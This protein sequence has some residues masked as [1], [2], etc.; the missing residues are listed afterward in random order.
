MFKKLKS[1]PKYGVVIL[2][3]LFLGIALPDFG[4]F[5]VSSLAD[6]LRAAM[7][8][9]QSQYSTIATAPLLAGIIFGFL[10]GVLMD[11]FGIKVVTASIVLTTVGLVMRV[12]M[13]SFLTQYIAGILIG[14]AATFINTTAPKQALIGSV[15]N[16]I[17]IMLGCD[18]S[19]F[20]PYDSHSADLPPSSSQTDIS[21]L[22]GDISH[23]QLRS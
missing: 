5:Q 17:S 11:R 13:G 8:L 2:L 12:P 9:S 1:N 16:G 4:Q 3:M 19:Y 20:S 15:D 22:P 7:D 10:S 6:K 21:A 18:V 23:D 14:T